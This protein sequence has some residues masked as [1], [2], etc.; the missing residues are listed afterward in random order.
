MFFIFRNTIAVNMNLK[1]QDNLAALLRSLGYGDK[2]E[3]EKKQ[4]KTCCLF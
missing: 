4:Q 3:E 2:R 1:D